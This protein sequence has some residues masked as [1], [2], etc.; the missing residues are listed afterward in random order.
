MKVRCIYNT[1][2]ALRPYEDKPL[3]D[4]Q[5]GKFGASYHTV[6]GVA[7]D[8]EYIVMGM[9]FGEGELD[10]LL[11]DDGYIFAYPYLLFEVIDNKL[12][13]SWFFKALKDTDNHFPYQM[14]IWGYYELVFDETHYEKLVDRQE[15]A[16]RVYFRRKIELEKELSQ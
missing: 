9:I 7:I 5:F 15:D 6:F 2:K 3:A 1:G 8:K 4:N 11:D 16:C 14:A 10:Y 12:P 13:S